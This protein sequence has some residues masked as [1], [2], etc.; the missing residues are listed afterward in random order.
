MSLLIYFFI[1]FADDT[2]I[3]NSHSSIETLINHANSELDKVADW[4]QLNKLTLNLDKTNFILFRSY[5]KSLP[6]SYPNLCIMGTPIT[7]VQS[8]KFLG[9]YVDQHLSWKDHNIIIFNISI[10][11][12]KNLGILTRISRILPSQT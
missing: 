10:K 2:N 8:F 1:L 6:D 7:Q 3:F 12:A 4:F 11:I 9:V 5:K